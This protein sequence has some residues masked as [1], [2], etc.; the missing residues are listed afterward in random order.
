[1]MGLLLFAHVGKRERIRERKSFLVDDS[2][3]LGTIRMEMEREFAGKI[4]PGRYDNDG[5]YR[6]TFVGQNGGLGDGNAMNESYIWNPYQRNEVRSY[7][8][9]SLRGS[10]NVGRKEPYFAGRERWSNNWRK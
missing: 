1:M 4:E 9:G 8:R 5:S 6:S 3:G 7:I 2:S 10:G